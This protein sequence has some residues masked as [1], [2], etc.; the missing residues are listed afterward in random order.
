MVIEIGLLMIKQS[1]AGP[2]FAL[3]FEHH[4]AET[5]PRHITEDTDEII[6]ASLASYLSRQGGWDLVLE[7]V[8]TPS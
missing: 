8:F 1:R 3:A 6:S 4:F 2:F 5:A 7:T